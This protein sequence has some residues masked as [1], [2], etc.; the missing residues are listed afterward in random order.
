V[1]IAHISDCY[2]PRLGGI[3]AQVHGLARRQIAAGHEVTVLTATPGPHGERHGAHDVV[4][5][6]PV[7]RLA[8]RLP[9]GV[10]VNPFAPKDVRSILLAGRYDVVHVHAGVVSPFAYDGLKVVLDLGRPVVVT[11]HCV[12]GHSEPLGRVWGRL[13]DWSARPIAFTAVSDVAAEPLRRIVGPEVE[14]TVLPNGVDVAAWRA[15]PIP[16]GDEVRLVSAMRL[17]RRKRPIPLLHMVSAVRKRVPASVRLHLSILG[18]G[19]QRRLMNAVVRHRGMAEWVDLPGRLDRAQ[20]LETYRRSDVYLAPARME[21]FGIAAIEARAAGLPVV[22]RSDSGIREFVQHDVEGLLAAG[23]D[24][25]VDAIVR[26]VAEPAL[27]Q[28]ISDYNHTNPPIQD[29]DHVVAIADREYARA[30]RILA[31][32]AA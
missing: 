6:V 28:R 20:L 14:V 12:L 3:E 22:A 30:V 4:E 31:G 17:A 23:D 1:R 32:A 8:I 9:F 5:G 7:H 19:P 10:P 27:R 21:S 18:A 25:M 15:T 11:W 2:L 26:I 24:D 29:W 13:R 16:H